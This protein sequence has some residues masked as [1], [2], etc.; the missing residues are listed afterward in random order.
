MFVGQLRAMGIL[1]GCMP[2]ESSAGHVNNDLRYCGDTSGMLGQKGKLSS[3]DH[4]SSEK[5]SDPR[6]GSGEGQKHGRSGRT[7]EECKR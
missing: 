3:V 5:L 4:D 6:A 7:S 1:C 2:P